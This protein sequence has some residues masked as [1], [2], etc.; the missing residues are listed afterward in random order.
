M[1][2]NPLNQVN[3]ASG[4]IKS[5]LKSELAL[6]IGVVSELTRRPKGAMPVD[7]AV[8]LAGKKQP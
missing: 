1:A 3:A 8:T 2:S 7:T 6:N 4:A 5:F